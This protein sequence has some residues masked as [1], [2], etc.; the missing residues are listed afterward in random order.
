MNVTQLLQHMTNNPLTQANLIRSADSSFK[1][2]K[3][4]EAKL[5]FQEVME[6]TKEKLPGKTLPATSMTDYP[7][8]SYAFPSW[9]N[10]YLPEK[11]T[12]SS[13][14]NH[15]FWEFAGKLS[16]DNIIT[17]EERNQLRNYLLN[18]PFHKA[19]LEKNAFRAEYE[20]EIGEYNNFLLNTFQDILKE[21]DIDSRENY[22]QNVIL[23]KKNSE[24]LHIEMDTRLK[25]NPRVLELM[26][27]LLS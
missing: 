26:D 14:L 22:Y 18:D 3:N 8:E 25:S 27:M 2:N 11:A 12:L 10:S 23:D 16:E 24:K 20:K 1:T 17:D 5:N 7:I 4:S 6:L 9:F 15:G 13:E 19:E 21:N